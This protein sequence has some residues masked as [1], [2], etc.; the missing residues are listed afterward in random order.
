MRFTNF[1]RIHL[2]KVSTFLLKFVLSWIFVIS[3]GGLF[4]SLN[5]CEKKDKVDIWFNDTKQWFKSNVNATLGNRKDIFANLVC[6]VNEVNE[7][8]SVVLPNFWSQEPSYL[9]SVSVWWYW[10][11]FSSYNKSSESIKVVWSIGF[12]TVEHVPE[13]VLYKYNSI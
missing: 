1:L 2:R 3:F 11:P 7:T 13:L 10:H 9:M 6:V 4:H 8:S 5:T 12:Q